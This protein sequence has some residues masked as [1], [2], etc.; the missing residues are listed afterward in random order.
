M[1]KLIFYTLGLGSG[2]ALCMSPRVWEWFTS[3][4]FHNQLYSVIWGL[5]ILIVILLG[6]PRKDEHRKPQPVFTSADWQ[7]FYESAE[8]LEKSWNNA[9]S[10]TSI[11]LLTGCAIYGF[12]D[13]LQR[14]QLNWPIAILALSSLFNAVA[15]ALLPLSS[16]FYATYPFQKDGFIHRCLYRIVERILPMWH[17]STLFVCLIQT[18]AISYIILNIS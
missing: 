14:S 4:S 17:L 15:S 10:H 8:N 6:L 13:E 9:L 12:S 1:Y 18:M 5:I 16:F 3:L 7:K 11:L 2:V